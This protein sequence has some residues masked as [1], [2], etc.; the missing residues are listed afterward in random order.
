MAHAGI[1]IFQMAKSRGEASLAR[2]L[3]GLVGR[4]A[5]SIS[6]C[7]SYFTV[8]RYH[9]RLRCM[10]NAA[11]RRPR[12]FNIVRYIRREACYFCGEHGSKR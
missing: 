3:I 1:N 5:R 10:R 2:N 9:L 8:N 12:H 4:E 6:K 7:V 11:L